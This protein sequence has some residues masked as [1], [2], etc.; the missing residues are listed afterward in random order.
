MGPPGRPRHGTNHHAAL[1]ARRSYESLRG[2]AQPGQSACFGT[3]SKDGS[4][5]DLGRRSPRSSSGDAFRGRNPVSPEGVRGCSPPIA[6]HPVTSTSSRTSVDAGAQPRSPAP[7][8]LAT[9][10][11]HETRAGS[12]MG[13]PASINPEHAPARIARQEPMSVAREPS[14]RSQAQGTQGQGSRASAT[15]HAADDEPAARARP[16]PSPPTRGPAVQHARQCGR[17]R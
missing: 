8:L 4:H 15:A 9:L 11:A 10:A 17:A 1:R 14:P 6:R 5:E 2:V 12:V 13:T 16:L 3:R 7:A